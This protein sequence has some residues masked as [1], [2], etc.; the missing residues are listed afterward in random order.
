VT[1]AAPGGPAWAGIV[2]G[3][4][5]RRLAG[6][7]DARVLN[8]GCAEPELLAG[9]ERFGEAWGVDPRAEVI[10]RAR[11][12]GLRRVRVARPERLPVEAG[13]VDLLVMVGVLEAADDDRA[14][15]QE[16][17]RALAPA[18]LLVLGVPARWP[19]VAGGN[20]ARPRRYAPLELRLA[21]LDAG[22]RA[23]RLTRCLAF[24]R[25]ASLEAQLLERWDLPVGRSL[26]AIARRRR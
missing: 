6:E 20:R 17:R 26:L 22:L 4:L 25:T 1:G 15:L 16:S 11:A 10:A 23:Q 13:T 14:V 8:V 3:L 19:G 18:G 9:L 24:R 2:L 12:R 5:A 21:L 7:S